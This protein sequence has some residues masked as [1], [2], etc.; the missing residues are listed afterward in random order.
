MNSRLLQMILPVAGVLKWAGQD[1]EKFIYDYLRLKIRTRRAYYNTGTDTILGDLLSVSRVQI[2][3][4]P[5]RPA[6]PG[7]LLADANRREQLNTSY[8]GVY[9]I[10]QCEMVA[11]HCRQALGKL[12]R[13]H[14]SYRTHTDEQSIRKKLMKN[15]LALTED[16]MKSLNIADYLRVYTGMRNLPYRDIV[17]FPLDA[18]IFTGTVPSPENEPKKK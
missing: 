6:T 11:I 9:Y 10:H 16:E 3:D 13:F 14:R 8:C 12:L 2:A 17:A 5:Q 1:E 18:I 4:D 7:S 15:P